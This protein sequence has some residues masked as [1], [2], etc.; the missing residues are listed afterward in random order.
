MASPRFSDLDEIELRNLLDKYYRLYQ[1]LT[2]IAMLIGLDFVTKRTATVYLNNG[3]FDIQCQTITFVGHTEDSVNA[4][5]A[6]RIRTP[7]R[8]S[9][10]ARSALQQQCASDQPLKPTQYLIEPDVNAT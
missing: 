10:L 3:L 5:S 2:V 8:V 4:L 9:I 6:I 1:P 7:Q